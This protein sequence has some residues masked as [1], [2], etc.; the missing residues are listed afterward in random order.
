[1]AGGF[2]SLFKSSV[3][4]ACDRF[5][6]SY[7][8]YADSSL[9]A[10]ERENARKDALAQIQTLKRAQKEGGPAWLINMPKL[11]ARA[12]SVIKKELAVV[13]PVQVEKKE[14]AKA[15]EKPPNPFVAPKPAEKPPETKPD[16]KKA[17]K[18]KPK[19]Q[20]TKTEAKKAPVEDN[21]IKIKRL[22]ARIEELEKLDSRYYISPTSYM[23]T[24]FNPGEEQLKDLAHAG[25]VLK[26]GE[27]YSRDE[28]RAAI[29]KEL[30][31]AET[32]LK[33]LKPAEAKKERVITD[34]RQLAGFAK[35]EYL[36]KKAQEEAKHA[37]PKKAP[38]K[39]YA[40]YSRYE[41]LLEEARKKAKAQGKK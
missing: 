17:A 38:E 19:P 26:K 10:A 37:L 34:A 33:K 28:I 16:G 13:K 24:K 6:A 20:E 41:H 23:R 18:K 5:D 9:S 30:D 4:N 22:E 11:R 25:I 39:V 14:E 32:G 15:P 27:K 7:K 2:G 35:Y 1:M 40:G 8:K 36:Q 12:E 21:A 31:K 29:H 3:D